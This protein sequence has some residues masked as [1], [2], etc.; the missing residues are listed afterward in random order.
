MAKEERETEQIQE[1][2]N[3]YEE[4]TSLKTL[5]AETYDI[6]SKINSLEDIAIAQEHYNLY[7][8]L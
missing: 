2:F 5:A 8:L 7:S 3:L 4:Q 6:L 1:L